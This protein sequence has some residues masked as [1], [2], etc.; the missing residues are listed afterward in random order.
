MHNKKLV[1]VSIRAKISHACTSSFNPFI[2]VKINVFF[3]D[4]C[5]TTALSQYKISNIL[6]CSRQMEKIY[7]VKQ[8]ER[9]NNENR[10]NG[11]IRVYCKSIKYRNSSTTSIIRS[12]FLNP[13]KR[14]CPFSPNQTHSFS[15]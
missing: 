6:I 2:F 15:L 4:Y 8:K 1:M 12:N 9:K 13:I 3:I 11:F 14:K 7:Y 10:N 5:L